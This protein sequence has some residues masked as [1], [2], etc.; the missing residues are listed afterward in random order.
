MLRI[1]PAQR[2]G[3]AGDRGLADGLVL[4][5]LVG[6]GEVGHDPSRAV[7]EGGGLDGRAGHRPAEH[8]Q[9]R[10]MH[11]RVGRLQVFDDRL[12]HLP[13]GVVAVVCVRAPLR[14]LLVLRT[15]R[16]STLG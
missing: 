10:D 5:P 7:R 15:P 3:E 12:G 4:E 1:R 6:R 2:R 13:V 8:P 16:P 14:H 11:R 9:L